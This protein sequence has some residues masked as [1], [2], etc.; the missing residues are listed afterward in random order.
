[1]WSHDTIRVVA[2]IF[3]SFIGAGVLGLPFAFKQAG[4]F[5]GF[6][7]MILVSYCSVQAML[8][9]IDCKYKVISVL[10]GLTS[11]RVNKGKGYVPV[12]VINEVDIDDDEDNAKSSKKSSRW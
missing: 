2:N 8:L 7:V 9:L 5:E 6:L 1:M 4:L 10:G 3:I 11:V 12:N